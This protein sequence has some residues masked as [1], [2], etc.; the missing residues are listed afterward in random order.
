MLLYLMYHS[1]RYIAL[2]PQ[3]T[4]PLLPTHFSCH[5]WHFLRQL[6]KTYGYKCSLV[7]S[8]QMVIKKYSV[9]C[10]WV[11]STGTAD[12]WKYHSVSATLSPRPGTVEP[13]ARSQNDHEMWMFW[14]S[15]GHQSSH[16]SVSVGFCL[17]PH[18]F[19]LTKCIIFTH[20]R[21]IKGCPQLGSHRRVWQWQPDQSPSL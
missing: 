2:S 12:L 17:L 15:S 21:W 8:L 5:S 9:H 11:L 7:N 20:Q 1:K 13:L 19:I 6:W 4:L 16:D 18:T 3:N 10:C 14:T